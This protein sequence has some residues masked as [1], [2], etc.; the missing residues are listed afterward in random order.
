MKISNSYYIFYIFLGG[1]YYNSSFVATDP[2]AV[3]GYKST[4]SIGYGKF[5]GCIRTGFDLVSDP[6]LL[7]G[8]AFIIHGE[9]G[10][11]VS[12]GLIADDTMVEPTI[13]STSTVPIPG[14]ISVARQSDIGVNGFVSVMANVTE[15]ISDGVCYQ[16]YAT[17]L[18]SD[19]ESFLLNT[20][21][22]ECDVANGCGSH[23]HSGTGCTDVDEQGGHY[24]DSDELE[25][26]PWLEE[27]YYTTDGEGIGA[28]VGCAITGSNADDYKERPFIVHGVDG[29]RL[30]CGILNMT[31]NMDGEG[32]SGSQG[33]LDLSKI[34]IFFSF[35]VGFG[36]L[37]DLF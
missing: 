11:R 1:H 33:R 22:S 2:W 25:V 13:L 24:Y 18:E 29:S 34:S 21:S 28:F 12:C 3:V 8:K 14:A 27:S 5:A 36:F 37:V 32:D 4:D 31:A 6:S 35:T 10:S 23:I 30:S 26:D 9:D 19:V 17:G 15:G 16:G 7:N 20:G